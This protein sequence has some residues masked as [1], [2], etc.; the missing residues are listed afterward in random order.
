MDFVVISLFRMKGRFVV[1][2]L[3]ITKYLPVEL[4]YINF[5]EHVYCQIR[6]HDLYF[7]IFCLRSTSQSMDFVVISL[8]RMKESFVVSIL[9]LIVKK[10]FSTNYQ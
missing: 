9:L 1:S 2:I 10:A 5:F 7:K 3:L 4:L 6:S 8:F